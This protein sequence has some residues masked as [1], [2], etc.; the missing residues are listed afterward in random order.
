MADAWQLGRRA[1][2]RDRGDRHA[3]GADLG[4]PG[5]VE[6]RVRAGVRAHRTALPADPGERVRQRARP[7]PLHEPERRRRGLSRQGRGGSRRRP[8]ERRRPRRTELLRERG[9]GPRL[10]EPTGDADSDRAH[11]RLRGGGGHADP[12]RPGRRCR[13][14]RCRDLRRVQRRPRLEPD[15]RQRPEARGALLRDS[16]G[17]RHPRARLRGAR[18]SRVS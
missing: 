17:A 6:S 5:H 3:H 4:R 13:A 9:H 11:G 2:R 12:D 14:V 8:N 1:R 15:P 16:G 18:R 10:R 7:D